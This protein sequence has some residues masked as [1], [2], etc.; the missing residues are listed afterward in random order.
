MFGTS[1]NNFF[2][3]IGWAKKGILSFSNT[4]LNVLSAFGVALF[5]ISLVLAFVE[6]V[7][8]MIFPDI[9]PKGIT[10]MLVAVIFFGSINLLG[11]SIIG[12]YI[13][14]IFEEV[15]RRPHF[16]RRSIIVD[17]ETRDAA[18]EQNALDR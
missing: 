12:E 14:K 6:I 10:T 15:K 16:I 5:G 18:N 2:K 9:A 4:P 8:K 13:A 7:L 1:T 3:N 11:I 17:G